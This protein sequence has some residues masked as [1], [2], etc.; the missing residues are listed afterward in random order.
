MRGWLSDRLYSTKVTKDYS[1]IKSQITVDYWVCHI[2]SVSYIHVSF[3]QAN[4]CWIS[5]LDFKVTV[6]SFKGLIGRNN[7]AT[8][9][10]TNKLI[11]D[12][13]QYRICLHVNPIIHIPENEDQPR[14]LLLIKHNF[15]SVW[16]AVQGNNWCHCVLFYPFV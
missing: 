10:G 12:L 7:F 4:H 15:V 1:R 3:N 11:A 5:V 14:N 13:F 16:V 9:D 6:C 8:V 2:H